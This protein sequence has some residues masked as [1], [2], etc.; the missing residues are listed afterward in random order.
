MVHYLQDSGGSRVVGK[1][2]PAT[3]FFEDLKDMSTRPSCDLDWQVGRSRVRRAAMAPLHLA[4]IGLLYFWSFPGRHWWVW[5]AMV[6]Y[7]WFFYHRLLRFAVWTA[8]TLGLI[9]RAAASHPLERL[10]AVAPVAEWP[11]F[12]LFVPAYRSP[13]CIGTVVRILQYLQYPRNLWRVVIVT[14]QAEIEAQAARNHAIAEDVREAVRLARAPSRVSP[15]Q[16]ALILHAADRGG[17]PSL[18]YVSA[19][20]M[21]PRATTDAWAEFLLELQDRGYSPDDGVP[22]EAR[23]WLAEAASETAH[24][25]ARAAGD[26]AEAVNLPA[27]CVVS[28]DPCGGMRRPSRAVH[29][30]LH[31]ACAA[32]SRSEESRLSAPGKLN[33]LEQVCSQLNPSTTEA[34]ES[35][36]AGAEGRFSHF[37]RPPGPRNKAAALNYAFC[38]CQSRGWLDGGTHVMVLDSDSHLHTGSLAL[39]ALEILQDPEPNVIRQLLPVTT[40]NFNGRNWLVRTIIAADSMAAPGR[41]ASN[42]RVQAR[43]DL[44]AGSGV[45]I[46]ASLLR[47]LASEYGEPWD[48]AIIC[49]DARMILSQYAL[50][51]GVCKKTRFVPSYVLEGAPE[52]DGVWQTYRAF[53]SQRVRWAIG[54]MDEV[55]ALWRAPLRTCLTDSRDFRPMAAPRRARGVARARRFLLMAVWLKEHLWWSGIILAPVLWLAAEAACGAPGLAV[56]CLGL[57]VLAGVPAALLRA[58]FTRHVA[59]LIPGGVSSWQVAGLFFSLLLTA[60]FFVLPVAWAQL[61][62]LTGVRRRLAATGWNPGTPKPGSR[63]DMDP[64]ASEGVA[65]KGR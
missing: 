41:W 63:L 26:L 29:R 59:R 48:T 25:A 12:V 61:L 9:A 23:K 24:A 13:R 20:G 36:L 56:R 46:P 50:L 64:L 33:S 7:Y 54:G 10:R 19:F 14:D 55:A 22:A 16:A 2:F 49:E 52:Q 27:G 37:V 62:C 31:R 44:T 53:W 51:D 40:T 57:A 30:A 32:R 43:A 1:R 28:P 21:S 34:V 11:R 6:A 4:G 38:A 65:G 5:L 35:C 60:L 3:V 47:Y 18:D 17:L 39:T 42:V 58:I 8:D 15:A 45:V